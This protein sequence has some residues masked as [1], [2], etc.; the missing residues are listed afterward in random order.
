MQAPTTT[1]AAP[2]VPL[3][4]ADIQQ[5]LEENAKMIQAVVENQN[6][7][8]MDE[9]LQYSKRLQENL[10]QLAALADSQAVPASQPPVTQ[11]SQ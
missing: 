6:L 2:A 3:T 9:C 11:Q 5:M 4:T 8:K 7:N 10:M 1:G